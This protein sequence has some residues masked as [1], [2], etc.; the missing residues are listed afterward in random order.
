LRTAFALGRL[1]TLS[2][3]SFQQLTER[4][5]RESSDSPARVYLI[6]AQ[7]LHEEEEAA[8][9]ELIRQL[10]VFLDSTKPNEQLEA[11]TVLGMRGT[12]EQRPGLT[13]LLQSREP[14]ARIGGANGLLHLLR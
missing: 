7:L 10:A 8:R 12:V 5:R 13:R 1:K 4:V 3:A 14:D 2:P 9:Q 11:A 6:A